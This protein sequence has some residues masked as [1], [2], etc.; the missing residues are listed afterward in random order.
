MGF[1]FDSNRWIVVVNCLAAAAVVVLVMAAEATMP[2][3]IVVNERRWK[4]HHS[5]IHVC[6]MFWHGN[7]RV[8]NSNILAMF[9]MIANRNE[10][11]NNRTDS[12]PFFQRNLH[13]FY[14]IRL[15]INVIVWVFV[16]VVC[17]TNTILSGFWFFVHHIA[18]NSTVCNGKNYAAPFFVKDM[19]LV[20]KSV[21]RFIRRWGEREKRETERE[22]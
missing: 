7:E 18:H 22:K 13:V 20:E 14:F 5:S 6:D 16:V 8:Q 12:V 9:A 1:L 19:F 2:D 4:K 10:H 11:R 15:R 17:T 21:R 3:K